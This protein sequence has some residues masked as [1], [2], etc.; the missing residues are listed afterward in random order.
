MSK[1]I[2]HIGIDDTD[3]PKGMCTTFLAY[4][5]INRLKKENVDFLDFPNLVRFNPN[6]PWKT[7][8]NGAVGIKISTSNPKKIKNLVKKFV[9]QYSDIKNGANPGLVFC[10]D[11]NIPN[12]F[13]KLSSDAMWKLIHR[14]EAKKI[15]S[16]HNLDF[17]YLGNGQG[18][19]GATSVIGYN[20]QDETYELLSYRKPSKFG[21]KRI[22]DK[23]KVKEMQ[24]KTY[25]NT[26][27]S[28]DS[29]KNKVLLMPHGPD[30]VFYG[31]RGENSTILISASK[32]IQPKEKLAGYLIFKSNQGTGDHLKNE[33]DVNNFLPYT[34][35]TLQGVVI[36]KPT[37]TKG[38][39]VFFS[40]IVDK[41]KINCAV[42]KPTRIT[43][44]AKELIVG[45][46]LKVGGGIRKATKTHQ[47]ILNLEFIQII[48]LEK[49]SKLINP[50]CKNCQKHMKS[51]GK[52]QGFQCV[53]CKKISDH[54][55]RQ[56][57]TRSVKEQ[58]YIPD[59]S[60]HR[61]L[62]KPVQRMKQKSK[63][64]KFNPNSPWITN[65]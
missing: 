24:E 1:Q 55:N 65:F 5:I 40:I 45:D 27:N 34:A 7:R 62:T 52:N 30:P 16:K 10:Q 21:K 4:K 51:K 12:E 19:V 22:L 47:R 36:E 41:V 63:S 25:P 44:V 50:F 23:S 29:K 2:L 54:K 35:G 39:H 13:S 64:E 31:V 18:L 28:F 48:K 26:F 20:F 15:L 8:G 61:H 17:F 60:A 57:I 14:N 49:K 37:V 58:I 43:D 11:E 56:F 38:G 59:V 42:Y 3:S 46:I 53:R 32:M 33:I 6:I 9:K